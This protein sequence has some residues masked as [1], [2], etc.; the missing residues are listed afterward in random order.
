MDTLWNE[1][2]ASEFES[3]PLLMRVYTSRLLGANPDLILHGGGNTSVKQSIENFF[4]ETEDL[5]YVKGSGCDLATIE[6]QKFSPVRLDTLIR[7]ADMETL[8]DT[9]MVYQQRAA[10]TDP[11]APNPSVEAILHALIPFLIVLFGSVELK[12]LCPDSHII[13]QLLVRIHKSCTGL[14]VIL[15]QSLVSRAGIVKCL[16]PLLL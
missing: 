2:E 9:E 7:M 12:V 14:P 6:E 16:K 1:K 10:M 8:S 11:G 5:L 4:G 13:E 3:D 15:L